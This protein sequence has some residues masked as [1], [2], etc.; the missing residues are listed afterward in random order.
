[1]SR[2]RWTRPLAQG[3]AQTVAALYGNVFPD[4]GASTTEDAV[5]YAASLIP[6]TTRLQAREA[7]P[8]PP[9]YPSGVQE[10]ISLDQLAAECR[11]KSG[12]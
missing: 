8:S 6:V 5:F 11:G 4:G 9:R 1:M 10:P 12:K 7:W 3:T 2:F